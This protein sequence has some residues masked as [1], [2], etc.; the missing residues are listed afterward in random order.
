MLT[1]F[2]TEQQGPREGLSVG[3][4]NNSSSEN[5]D[6]EVEEINNA[7]G[8]NVFVDEEEGKKYNSDLRSGEEEATNAVHWS[9]NLS[10][11]NVEPS[12][13]PHGPKK[14]LGPNL[15]QSSYK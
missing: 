8:V 9:S 10:E 3:E 2:L 11:I 13:I 1:Y 4:E 7:S 15:S 12:S 5:R 6:L 14:D